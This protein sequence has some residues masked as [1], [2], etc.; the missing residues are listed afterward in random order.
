[1]WY[2]CYR[3]VE[4]KLLWIDDEEENEIEEETS[5]PTAPPSNEGPIFGYSEL[6]MVLGFPE[7]VQRA[8]IGTAEYY[9]S[10]QAC[11]ER[12]VEHLKDLSL[13]DDSATT[14]NYQECY[15]SSWRSWERSR[16]RSL[17]HR[18]IFWGRREHTWMWYIYAATGRCLTPRMW[19]KKGPLTIGRERPAERAHA[20][21]T[22]VHVLRTRAVRTGQPKSSAAR[23]VLKRTT[24]AIDSLISITLHLKVS[25]LL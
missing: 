5:Q 6:E 20:P 4:S 14:T 15:G 1:M 23:I 24:A 18:S 10:T 8:W 3:K 9:T 25:Y 12:V 21:T 2:I 19:L 16:G 17:R 7:S 11:L 13:E 22:Q